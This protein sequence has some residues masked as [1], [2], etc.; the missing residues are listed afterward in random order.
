MFLVQIT[1]VDSV[2]Q[3]GPI[4]YTVVPTAIRWVSGIKKALVCGGRWGKYSCVC[5][6]IYQVMTSS[7]R[8]QYKKN[9]MVR[10]DVR[11]GLRPDLT[12]GVQRI[13]P[14]SGPKPNMTGR[15]LRPVTGWGLESHLNYEYTVSFGPEMSL[16][17]RKNHPSSRH[18]L[19][20]PNTLLPPQKID[21]VHLLCTWPCIRF[22]QCSPE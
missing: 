11:D 7:S 10:P 17:V 6:S 20:P 3:V 12:T 2:S 8:E 1:G 13:Q 14:S 15:I 21:I 9:A 4:L 5:N 19:S 22:W 18:C 16:N